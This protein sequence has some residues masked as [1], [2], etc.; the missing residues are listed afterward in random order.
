MANIIIEKQSEKTAI[1]NLSNDLH[2]LANRLA[3]LA[4]QG[5]TIDE[6]ED[7]MGAISDLQIDL[8][9]KNKEFDK[10]TEY[11]LYD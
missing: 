5:Y 8:K 3:I 7:L 4:T 11:A 10:L 9:Y 6:M 1:L 2:K